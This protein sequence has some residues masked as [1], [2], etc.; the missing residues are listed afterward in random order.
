[1]NCQSCGKIFTCDNSTSCW[2]A[3]LPALASVNRDENCYCEVC[4]MKKLAHEVQENKFSDEV[5]KLKIRALGV[6]EK[7]IEGIDFHINEEGL[8]TFTSWYLLRRGY[9]CE[10]GCQNCPY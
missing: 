1:M 9:C 10:N 2:C 3:D 5:S 8:Y 6:P 7:L 4:L